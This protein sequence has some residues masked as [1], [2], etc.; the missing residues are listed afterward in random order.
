LDEADLA[1]AV[2]R[3]KWRKL[4]AWGVK[5]EGDPVVPTEVALCIAFLRQC[6][7][8]TK[9]KVDSY[10]LKHVAER[11]AGR[12][13]SNGALIAAATYLG[14]KMSRPYG[15]NVRIAAAVP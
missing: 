13:V 1:I 9:P 5:F 3:T 4:T 8:T 15:P 12:Y 6:R 7:A 14:L 11:W 2:A 10:R